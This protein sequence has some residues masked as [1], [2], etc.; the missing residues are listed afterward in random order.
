MRDKKRIILITGG[1]QGLGMYLAKHLHK[2][3]HTIIILGTRSFKNIPESYKKIIQDYY[4]IDLS[5]L[6]AVNIVLSNIIRKYKNIDVL[7]NN[8]ALRIFKNYIEFS[9]A[10]IE[11]Y[12]NVNFKIPILLIRKIFPIMRKNGY[13]R[14]INISSKSA[15]WGYKSGSMY[16]STKSALIKFT[17]AFGRELKVHNNNVT[18]NVICPDS[19]RTVE[20]EWL[21]GCNRIMSLIAKNVDEILVSN[22]NAEV[23][24][25]L[26]PK[27]KFVEITH[28]CKKC[29]LWLIKY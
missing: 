2:M 12:I 9:E 13:G 5:D 10:E 15:F 19:F 16:C 11:R 24:P 4:K 27:T 23:I 6:T 26:L 7:I 8:A 18:I 29:L 28:N 1:T 22:R 21:K 20:G 3:G 17:E 14:I 25:V